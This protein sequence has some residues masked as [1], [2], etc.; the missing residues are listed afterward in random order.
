MSA[1]PNRFETPIKLPMVSMSGCGAPVAV[2]Q[3]L[4]KT[5]VVAAEAGAHPGTE[6]C[7]RFEAHLVGWLGFVPDV[8]RIFAVQ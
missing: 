6:L 1:F 3:A 5:G 8:V 2:A 4:L 7:A